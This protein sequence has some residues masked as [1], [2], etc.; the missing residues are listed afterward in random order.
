MLWDHDWAYTLADCCPM[1]EYDKMDNSDGPG[2][3]KRGLALCDLQLANCHRLDNHDAVYIFDEVGS[4]KT[5]TA[6]LMALHYL[7]NYRD[8]RDKKVLVI[9]TNALTQGENGGQFLNDWY[10]KLPFAM[11][12]LEGRVTVI[13]H[14]NQNIKCAD[15]SQY[16]LVI[17]D[18][19]QEFLNPDNFRYK[20]LVGAYEN[21]TCSQ[22]EKVV[23]LT[24]TPI[25]GTMRGSCPD[26]EAAQK[27]LSCYR[28]LARLM[29]TPNYQRDHPGETWPE[30][31]WSDQLLEK[32]QSGQEQDLICAGFDLSLPFTRYFKDTIL[33][34]NACKEE[35]KSP[36]RTLPQLWHWN[37][38]L[39]EHD[40]KQTKGFKLL[41]HIRQIVDQEE[42]EAAPPS[43]FLVFVRY[44]NEGGTDSCHD[45]NAQYLFDYLT[46]DHCGVKGFPGQ[47]AAV[48]GQWRSDGFYGTD[49]SMYSRPEKSDSLPRVLILTYQ[50]AEA[51]VNLPG[52]NYVVN[53]H[54][55]RF[56]S[57]LEQRF[58]RVDRRDS[59]YKQIHVSYLLDQSDKW[60]INTYNFHRA[61]NTALDGVIPLLPSRNAMLS[62]DI[63]LEHMDVREKAR[64]R[65]EQ[66]ERLLQ[67]DIAYE[68][69][70]IYQRPSESRGDIR[71]ETIQ[72]LIRFFEELDRKERYAED[73]SED[74]KDGFF[75]FKKEKIGSK[76]DF[77]RHARRVIRDMWKEWRE[78]FSS[79]MDPEQIV[80]IIEKC[81]NDIF[82]MSEGG[83]DRPGQDLSASLKSITLEKCRELTRDSLEKNRRYLY[84]DADDIHAFQREKVRP[85]NETFEKYKEKMNQYFCDRFRENDLKEVF[86]DVYRL[87]L[88]PAHRKTVDFYRARVTRRIN[89]DYDISLLNILLGPWQGLAG[90]YC[91]LDSV[92]QLPLFK[93]CRDFERSLYRHLH[94][95]KGGLRTNYNSGDPIALACYDVREQ[96]A[97]LGLIP[98]EIGMED[99]KREC[100]TIELGNPWVTASSW[101]QL[102]AKFFMEHPELDMRSYFYSNWDW[103]KRFGDG[104][105]AKLRRRGSVKWPWPDG[106]DIPSLW[107]TDCFTQHFIDAC[108][109]SETGR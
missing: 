56:P 96:A 74:D 103:E 7:W 69:Y 48:T 28:T 44:V 33:N 41:D 43:R 91:F 12:Q 102:A 107:S 58:G 86:P 49:L 80:P 23:F 3:N 37:Q 79:S 77:F 31:D 63:L 39:A 97:A 95:E 76:E 4:G 108:C 11:L 109:P 42:S 99:I 67:Q 14:H 89:D 82:Y 47:V 62:K 75:N 94:N 20:A 106:V 38:D 68:A 60:D 13:N 32:P 25:K 16:G 26:R 55:S 93:M 34:L 15:P 85:W 53:Y 2:S 40:S 52:F 17:I 29:L 10:S 35:N 64:R 45:E 87:K 5:I 51:G 22:T 70:Q 8:D 83:Q 46:R 59:A 9:T 24:A 54:I 61:V 100:L 88:N 105:R 101:Y 21:S 6:G 81:G 73:E 50:I 90:N 92:R 19:A 36:E 78:A 57:A 65:T 84:V 27:N 104:D 98:R 1:D 71:D 72:I 66:M 30:M 18:E